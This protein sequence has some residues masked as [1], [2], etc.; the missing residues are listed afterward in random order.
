VIRVVW[1]RPARDDLREIRAYVAR[2]SPHYT[3][4]VAERL[5]RAVDRL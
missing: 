2:D 1:T 4:L 3:R 5:V